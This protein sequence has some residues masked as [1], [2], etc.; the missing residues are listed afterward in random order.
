MNTNNGALYFGAG[1]DT[2][3]FRRDIEAMR[4][5]I[6][7][8]SQVTVQVTHNMD[9]AFKNVFA[10]IAGYFSVSA[11]KDFVTELI[12]VRG[13]FQKTEIAFATMLG[14]A[15]KAQALMGQMVEL[16]AKTPF[17]LQDVSSG[18][19]QLLAFQVPANQVVDTLTRLGNIAA[20]LS[21]PLSRINLVYG[22]VKAKGKLMGDDLRQFTEAGIPMVAELAKK[23]GKTTSEISAM[24]SAGKIGFK[25]VKDVLFSMTNEGGMFFNLM[26]KQSKSLS[27]Q[28]SNL[29]DTW[30][31]MLN[32]IGE[33]QEGVL[34]DGIQGLT[35]LVEHY[36]D[37][38]KAILTIVEIYGAYRAALIVTSVLQGNIASASIIQGFAN[39]IKMIRGATVAQEAL[40]A[41]SL[42]N[43]YVLLATLIAAL[44]AI[45]Y[46]YRNEI[47]ELIGI[48]EKQTTAQK[49]QEAVMTS[50]NDSFGKGVSQTKANI[51]E[52]INIIRN[53]NSSLDQRKQAYERLIAIDPTFRGTLDAQYQATRKLGEA[54][55]YVV[56]KIDAFAMAQAKA[57]A[58]RKYLEESFEEQFKAGALKTQVMDADA[59]A[60]KWRKLSDDAEKAGKAN[61]DYLRKAYDAEKKRD[62]LAKKWREQQNIANEKGSIS[63]TIIRNNNAEIVQDE[64]RIKFLKERI[65][66]NIDSGEQI[67]IYRKELEKLEYK[68]SGFKPE[69]IK[70]EEEK[71]PTQGWAAKIKA[72]IQE[73][74]AQLDS[75]PTQSAY[76]KIKDKIKKLNALLNPKD[77]T[78]NRQL[79]EI[80]PE[81]S[82]KDL[83]R[84]A[85]LIK[86]ALE[87]VENGIVKLRK[88]DKYGSDKDK[89]GNPL[90]TGE[91]VSVEEAKKRL[92]E[93]N[94]KLADKRKEIEVRSF[95]EEISEIKRQIE[96]RD[97]LL[98]LGYS[99]ETVDDMFPAVKDKSFIQYLNETGVAL[100]KLKGKEPAE[101]LIRLQSILSEYNSDPT[102]IE[103]INNQIDDLKLKFKG[104]ELINKLEQFKKSS[105][106]GMSGSDK[107]TGDEK[108]A[109]NIAISKAIQDELK[110]QKA[111]Y[112][113]LLNEHKSFS[114]RKIA[115]EKDTVKAIE[116]IN[117]DNKL[118]DQ[119]KKGYSKS[120]DKKSKEEISQLAVEELTNSK[121]WMALYGNIDDL[122]S[123]QMQV[124]LTEIEGKKDQL[125]K[126]LTPVDFKILL[127][128]FRDVKERILE[129]NPF[130]TLLDSVQNL[131][132]AFGQQSQKAGENAYNGFERATD[133][134]KGT[135]KATKGIISALTPAREYM[136][137]AANDAIDTIEQVA[138]M[139]M[140]MMQ[141]IDGT[142]KAV[143][144]ALDKASWS[145]WITAI[146]SIIYT[147][148]KAIVSLFSWIAGNKTKKLNEEIKT[149][150]NT[151]DALKVSYEELQR[152]I[153]K[154]AGEDHL[155]RQRELIA[156]LQEQ[157]RILTDIRSK[158][159]QKKKADSD[160]I[161][162]YTKEINDINFQIQQL[163]DDFFVSVT[164]TDFKDLAT[165]LA[166]AL[167]E[168]FGKGEDA[169]KSF[170]KVVNDVMKNAVINALKVK[171]LQPVAEEFVNKMYSSMGFGG[172]ASKEQEI[173]L[174]KYQDDL[175]EI[176]KK[177][178]QSTVLDQFLLQIDKDKLIEKIKQL[179]TAIASNAMAGSFDGLTSEEIAKLKG[180]FKD[181]PRLKAFLEGFKSLDDII[182]KT[183][184]NTQGLKGDIKGITEKT[185]GALEGQIN[186]MRIMQ[187][188]A[189]KHQK[190]GFEVMRSQ[191]LVQVQIEQ[192]T[193]PLK[194]I[195]DEIKSMNSKIK[196]GLAGIP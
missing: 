67:S 110:T 18:A 170:E 78:D 63:S 97:K 195:Y 2:T 32:K 93:I 7:G 101:N 183:I 27:G 182:D 187:A 23:F 99:K 65:K 136:S 43:P 105:Y 167:T 107:M 6:L 90:L 41:A 64:K 177:M 175:N 192:N 166:E 26:E 42:K 24:V 76:N 72:Q 1:I 55:D 60:K 59:E 119:Q 4:R 12:N 86:S 156:N 104:D 132:S 69:V 37:V 103:N 61:L 158:E 179:K 62:E 70:E 46:N 120:I 172:G 15:G 111:N 124:L 54:M 171:F 140:V 121:A 165:S 135:L 131:F 3:Q 114:D 174:K 89:K 149:L 38:G 49:A 31:Q 161:A 71:A 112:Q 95:D 163:V 57:A 34:S 185:A 106:T 146:I 20:G 16:A 68:L 74:E 113:N 40:N 190:N 168:G 133:G 180:D 29:G 100:E 14:D 130:L 81:D 191:L 66:L 148:I 117:A 30:D 108:N 91:K 80:F 56:G 115:I 47:G 79:T 51:T 142:V 139:G 141:A 181:D 52:L 21:V 128:N 94:K 88:I 50:Y 22:Q 196:N 159:S 137:D 176:E 83:E 152:V 162:S 58:A 154:T 5:E 73:L 134:I 144:A 25:D 164:T 145:N 147:V 157:Q 9:S 125:A 13:E 92:Q 85:Q 151:I 45:T 123:Y 96:V 48:I 160:K 10:G 19:K 82:I 189:L 39:L 178:S 184:D 17:S 129:E 35:Y 150:Q 143:K 44:I 98:Q 84:D 53:E 193:R 102:F 77:K 153:E 194:G 127:K 188:E 169:A 28:I 87:T 138:T 155:R 126:V 8:L 33:S 109:K 75:A 118:T 116:K 11:I 36:Q 173:Q 186:A 122:T